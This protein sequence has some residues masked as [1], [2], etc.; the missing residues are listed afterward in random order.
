MQRQV[1]RRLGGLV[2]VQTVFGDEAGQVAG[3]QPPGDVVTGG[4]VKRDRGIVVEADGV[5]KAG[6]LD[7][8]PV[9]APHALGTVE[10]PPRRTKPQCGVVPGQ[11]GQFPAIG[12]LVEGVRNHRQA[13]LV[14]EPVEEGLGGRSPPHGGCPPPCR[15][16]SG[17]RGR[18]VVSPRAGV[19][20]E[21]EAVVEAHGGHFDEH[22]APEDLGLTRVLRPG[23]DA[24]EERLR[25]TGREVHRGG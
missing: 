16:R 6:R 23:D 18:I 3:V 4:N 15:D 25:L 24:T 5:G 1:R 13:G 17:R 9:E 10:E 7:H 8:R 11:G 14:A 2:L 21:G 22:L 20:L 19:D 12:R